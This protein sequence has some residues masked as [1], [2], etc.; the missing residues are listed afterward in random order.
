V[1]AYF[2]LPAA[3]LADKI[4]MDTGNYYPEGTPASAEAIR[5][6]LAAATR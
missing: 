3:A 4:V 6:A 5:A 2:G 1:K